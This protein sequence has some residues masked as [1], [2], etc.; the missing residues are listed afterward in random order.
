[1]TGILLTILFFGITI[2][3]HELG[4]FCVAKLCKV[5]VNEFSIG[6]GPSFWHF[7]KGETKYSLR[8]FPIGGYVSMEGEETESEDKRSF[9]KKPIYQ[10]FAVLIAGALM[11]FILGVLLMGIIILAQGQVITTTISSVST[12][13]PSSQAL[14]MP[15]DTITE[16]NGHSFLCESDFRFEL[17]SIPYDQP[18]NLTVERNGEELQL[19]NVGEIKTNPDSSQYRLLGITLSTEDLNFKNFVS[20]TIGNSLFYAKLVWSSLID[21]FTG[22]VSITQLSGPVGITQVVDQAQ[23]IGWMSVV[24]LFAFLTIN[25]GIFNLIPFPA[26]DGGQILF[27]LIEAI[28][29]KPIKK[30]TQ[31]MINFIGFAFLILLM[32]FVT[33]KDI[34]F[35]F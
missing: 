14:L 27:L 26:L 23:S 34:V 22:Q 9:G 13:V 4:H 1:M 12:E 21:L 11:N 20:D 16:V 15:G 29:R 8:W 31:G 35:L 30:Q 6:M 10:R 33:I 18:V 17:Q 19:N 5:K 7:G 32:I 28:R 25:I 2:F 3:V 24:S